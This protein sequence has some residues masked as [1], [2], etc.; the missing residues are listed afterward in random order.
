MNWRFYEECLL[1]EIVDSQILNKEN[2]CKK[3]ILLTPPH[4]KENIINYYIFN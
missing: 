1:P 4:I 3:V 2:E